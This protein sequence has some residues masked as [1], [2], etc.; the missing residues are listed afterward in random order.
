MAVTMRMSRTH[1]LVCFVVIMNR[2]GQYGAD[3]H[4][5]ALND[6]SKKSISNV[7][8]DFM[9]RAAMIK[10]YVIDN[11]DEF[12]FEEDDGDWVKYKDY[13]D[14]LQECLYLQKKIEEMARLRDTT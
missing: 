14:L 9:G 4:L 8:G 12:L 2:L 7:C 10:R 5:Q 3:H 11:E 1:R 13:A 6:Y